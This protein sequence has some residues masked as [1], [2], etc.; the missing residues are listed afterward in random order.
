MDTGGRLPGI[1][2]PERN[3]ARL[4]GS[5][6]QTEMAEDTG[7]TPIWIGEKGTCE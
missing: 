6:K 7:I 4:T 3:T 1:K 2:K 5:T